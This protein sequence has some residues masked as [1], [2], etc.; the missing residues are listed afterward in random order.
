MSHVIANIPEDTTAVCQHSGMPVPK[1]YSVRKL[2]E[3]NCE[4]DKQ[5]RWHHK[6]IF[7]HGKVMMDS[8]QKEVQSDT[9]SI[10]RKEPGKMLDIEQSMERMLATIRVNVE[11]EPMHYVFNQTPKEEPKNPVTCTWG[12]AGHT[13]KSNEGTEGDTWKPYDRNHIPRGLAQ[14]LQKVPKERCR[15]TTPVVTWTMD[16]LQIKFLAEPTVPQLHKQRLVEVQELVLLVVSG[17]I[18]FH[19]QVFFVRH[20]RGRI[21]NPRVCISIHSRA[22]RSICMVLLR[23][24]ISAEETNKAVIQDFVSRLRVFVRSNIAHNL[25]HIF[26]SIFENQIASTRMIVDKRRYIVHFGSQSDIARFGVVMGLDLGRGKGW[27]DSSRHSRKERAKPKSR[28]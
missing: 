28:C 20:A 8:V 7:I 21:H 16:L 26:A 23:C 3:R 5:G 12:H 15:F 11:Q 10:V 24:R 1:D 4:D 22:S 6:S 17:I 25:S 14:R 13:R 27:Q 2:P 19:G 9:N 18:R